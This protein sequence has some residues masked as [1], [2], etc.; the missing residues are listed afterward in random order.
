ME[1]IYIVFQWLVKNTAIGKA[2]ASTYRERKIVQ[3]PA[4]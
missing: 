1:N 4:E 3:V 2:R